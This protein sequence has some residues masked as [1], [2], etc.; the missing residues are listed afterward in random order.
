[1]FSLTLIITKAGHEFTS[2]DTIATSCNPILQTWKP[3][4]SGIVHDFPQLPQ[5]L[6]AS[7]I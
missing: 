2:Q 1:M 3:A 7:V 6:A 5:H 4:F